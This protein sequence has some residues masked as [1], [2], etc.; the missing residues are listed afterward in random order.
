MKAG[1]IHT[2]KKRIEEEEMERER[3][4]IDREKE[5]EKELK[6]KEEYMLVLQVEKARV[7]LCTLFILMEIVFYFVLVLNF[8]L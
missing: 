6:W 4:K 5:K 1:E 3:A 8:L 7:T 2:N